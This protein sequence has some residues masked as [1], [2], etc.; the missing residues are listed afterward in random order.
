MNNEKAQALASFLGISVD[1]VDHDYD[2]TYSV[3]GGEYLVFTDDEADAA[4]DAS[5]DSYL[6]D[7]VF[8]DLPEVAQRYF[9]VASWKRDCLLSD[10]RGHLLAS[11]DGAEETADIDG[12]TY[13]IYRTN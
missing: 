1:D 12:T 4:A 13:Y 7:C 8:P 11:Y 5:M 3:E 6:D 2:E 10:G 9:D